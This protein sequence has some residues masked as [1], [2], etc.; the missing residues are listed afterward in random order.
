MRMAP[1]V[2]A[3]AKGREID[4][5][6]NRAKK[7]EWEMGTFSVWH[8]SIL[9]VVFFLFFGRGKVS[10]LMADLGKGISKFKKGIRDTDKCEG[11]P[12]AEKERDS[13]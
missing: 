4:V 1:Q 11:Q 6:R 2:V 3:R 13:L 9:L 5:S 8:W 12:A 10:Q 7:G